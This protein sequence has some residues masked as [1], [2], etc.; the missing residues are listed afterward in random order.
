VYGRGVSGGSYGHPVQ[1]LKCRAFQKE[2]F[3]APLRLDDAMFKQDDAIAMLN[4]TRAMGNHDD[5]YPTS[6]VVKG[7]H[8]RVFGDGIEQTGGII[9][10]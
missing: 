2:I 6:Q 9:R 5:G 10:D 4:R 1:F 7:F 8:Q 3:K